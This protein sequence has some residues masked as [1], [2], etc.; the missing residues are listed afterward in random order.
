M[1]VQLGET[2]DTMQAMWVGQDV[3]DL[4]TVYDSCQVNGEWNFKPS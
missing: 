2:A 3:S 1:Q 4:L